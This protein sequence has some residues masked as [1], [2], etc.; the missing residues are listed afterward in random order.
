MA[1]TGTDTEAGGVPGSDSGDSPPV[2]VANEF[3][4]VQVRRIR[5]RNGV[6][7]E[8]FSPRRGTRVHLDAVELDLLSFQEPE[9]FSE[10]LERTPRPGG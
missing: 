4:D 2:V 8:I 5:T 6:R 7:L 1:V 10:M 3:A 9:V